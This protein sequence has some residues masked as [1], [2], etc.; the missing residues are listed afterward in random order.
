[1]V[2]MISWS[3]GFEAVGVRCS[4]HSKWVSARR[5]SGAEG[6]EGIYQT[7]LKRQNFLPGFRELGMLT[8]SKSGQGDWSY[9]EGSS[10]KI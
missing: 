5:A 4:W 7:E 10:N 3:L 8:L 1:M 6:Q 9:L 2:I